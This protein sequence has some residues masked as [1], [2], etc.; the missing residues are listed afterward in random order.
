MNKKTSLA[1]FG[2]LCLLGLWLLAGCSKKEESNEAQ[3]SAP[4]PSAAPAAAATPIDP[5]YGSF[6]KRFGK[7]RRRSSEACEDRHE[8]RCRLQ[9]NQYG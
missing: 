4:A 8:P 9:G 7:A 3:P 1:M 2:L 6:G 5:S